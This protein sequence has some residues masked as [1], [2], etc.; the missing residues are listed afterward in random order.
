MAVLLFGKG[1][2][3]F[4]VIVAG[5]S[6]QNQPTL[7]RARRVGHPEVQKLLKGWAT[8]RGYRDSAEAEIAQG[9]A[10]CGEGG[11]GFQIRWGHPRWNLSVVVLR[12]GKGEEFFASLLRDV[13]FK[14][15]PPFE[16]HEEWATRKFKSCSEAVP[17]AGQATVEFMVL[18]LSR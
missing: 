8:R 1:W 13:Q 4:G 17:L 12:S 11:L 5:S 3:F 14:T 18:S 9:W 15:N 7:R 16:N 10:D 2:E 6:I